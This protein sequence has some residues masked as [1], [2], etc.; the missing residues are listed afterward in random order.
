MKPTARSPFHSAFTLIELLVVIAIIA[1][2]VGILL[3]S[4]A[5]ARKEARAVQAASNAR[6]IAIGV[7]TYTA[8]SKGYIP[9]SYV[10][11]AE[12]NSSRWVVADQRDQ[13]AGFS[14]QFGYV[15]WSWFLFENGG[16]PEGAFESPNAWNGGAP[17]TNPGP[18]GTPEAGQ[19]FD[20]AIEDKQVKRVGFGGNAALFPRNKFASDSSGGRLNRLVTTAGV[21]NST[22]G[23]SKTILVAE[24][25]STINHIALREPG[26]LMKSHR[27][28][29]PFVGS[30]GNDIYSEPD[31]GTVAR[32]SYPGENEIV[33]L[34]QLNQEGVLTGQSGLSILNAVGRHHPGGE[35]KLNGGTGNF[36]FVDAHVERTTVRE[37]IRQRLW[38][39]KFFSLTGRNINVQ[40]GP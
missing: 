5:S 15:H 28:I 8:D 25:I 31:S 39:D 38:G 33:P 40:T 23:A 6:Q 36:A 17:P 16:A 9:P 3:P 30:G 20:P 35:N 18:N 22:K 32:F 7:N 19:T 11:A 24:F 4:L 13:G 14:P 27:P 37:T 12:A 2:L 34:D 21:D 26:G 10:Y 29:T 1:L